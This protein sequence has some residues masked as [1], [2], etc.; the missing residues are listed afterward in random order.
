VAADPATARLDDLPT[1]PNDQ[2]ARPDDS[3]DANSTRRGAASTTPPAR[4]RPD[5]S[6]RHVRVCA[7]VHVFACV[8][9]W[10]FLSLP[11]SVCAAV[12]ACSGGQPAACLCVCECA[13]V[14]VRVCALARVC[15][16]GHGGAGGG[17]AVSAVAVGG[18]PARWCSGGQRR[19]WARV[20]FSFFL[21]SKKPS[22]RAN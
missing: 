14:R 6:A 17:R 9:V 3:T 10:V 20:G 19:W 7:R 16:V 15:A 5:D 2:A 4:P 13:C 21:F 12:V 8:R 22:P 1:H 11:L 18:V